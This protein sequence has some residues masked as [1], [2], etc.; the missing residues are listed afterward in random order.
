MQEVRS[1]ARTPSPATVLA[2]LALFF[3][4]TG[5]GVAA[6]AERSSPTAQASARKALVN[7]VIRA[8]KRK[9]GVFGG[10]SIINGS[11]GTLDIGNNSIGAMDFKPN[12]V[13]TMALQNMAVGL[14]NLKPNSVNNSI[15]QFNSV[16]SQNIKPESVA[17]SDLA[18]ESVGTSEFSHA[19]PAAGGIGNPNQGEL[20]S[21]ET[22]VLAIPNET[23]DTASMHSTTTDPHLFEAPQA[24]IYL[25][26]G[27]VTWNLTSGVPTTSVVNFSLRDSPDT[28]PLYVTSLRPDQVRHQQFTTAVHLEAG[29]TVFLQVHNHTDKAMHYEQPELSMVWI[30]PGPG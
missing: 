26:S 13:G 19:I 24:G 27:K 8:I 20:V 28:T 12:S 6:T 4:V 11:I 16:G 15:L 22:E 25:I 7:Q 23:F 5:F 10:R 3:S 29:D 1:G 9:R 2:A 21:A 30:A 18:D 14:F 17:S